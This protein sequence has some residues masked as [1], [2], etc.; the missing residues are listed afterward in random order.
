MT[1]EIQNDP[2]LR[3]I[4]AIQRTA[5]WWVLFRGVLAVL[6]VACGLVLV[7]VLLDHAFILQRSARAVF[8]SLFLIVCCV[9]L[10]ASLVVSLVCRVSRLYVARQVERQAPALRNALISYLQAGEDPRTP[11]Q[12]R[13]LL[14]DAAYRHVRSVGPALLA[15][16]ERSVRLGWALICI[17][18]LFALYTLLSPK[19]AVVSVERLFAPAA[20]IM[21]PTRTQI[22]AVLPGDVY[23][24]R[25]APVLIRAKVD[26]AVP[27]HVSALWSGQSSATSLCCFPRRG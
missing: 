7:G 10:A 2:I 8:F 6:I 17:S 26:G 25:G 19:S 1:Q 3:K 18:V 22:S 21:P 4:A 5:Q 20:D 11:P 12:V 27:E 15:R 23:V 16:P 24:L 9:G 13:A 14:Q